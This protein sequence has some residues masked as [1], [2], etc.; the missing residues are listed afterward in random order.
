MLQDFD[1]VQLE[2]LRLLRDLGAVRSLQQLQP[3]IGLG[4]SAPVR[5]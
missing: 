1:L 5:Q 3:L 2:L 4:R